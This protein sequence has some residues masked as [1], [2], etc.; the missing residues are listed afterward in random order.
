M[1]RGRNH[2]DARHTATAK[3]KQSG[4]AHP[5]KIASIRS[6]QTA[7][8]MGPQSRAKMDKTYHQLPHQQQT[9]L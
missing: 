5:N 8:L 6:L 7:A 4:I 2:S 1:E 9:H 3:P